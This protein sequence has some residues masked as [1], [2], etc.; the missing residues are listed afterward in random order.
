MYGFSSLQLLSSAPCKPLDEARD[1]INLGEAA[2]FAILM[3]SAE[4]GE[5][6][7]GVNFAGY[8]ES[9]DAWH[10]SH[11]HPQGLGAQLAIEQALSRAGLE[12]AAIDYVNL[13]GTSSRANDLI[14]GQV[15]ARMFPLSTDCSS[16]KAWTGHTLG[17]AGI[18]EALIAID[19]AVTGLVPGSLN[20]ETL[21][22]GIKVSVQNKNK[23]RSLRHVMSNSFGFGGNNC[24]LIFSRSAEA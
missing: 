1:G 10:M 20:L 17:A 11:P 5:D 12:A 9:S 7:S 14:E 23:H 24:C 2:G 13:H 3:R 22:P 8:G 6:T 15:I 4:A 19:A 21:D 16:T 18:T